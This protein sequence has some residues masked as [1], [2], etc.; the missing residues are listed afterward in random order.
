MIAWEVFGAV[1]S[2]EVILIGYLYTLYA[3]LDKIGNNFY[4]FAWKYSQI[5]EQDA[6]VASAE[7]I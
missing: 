7:N 6:S 1:N 3:Y 5:V 2:G 4:Q